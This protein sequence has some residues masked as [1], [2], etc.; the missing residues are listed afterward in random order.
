MIDVINHIGTKKKVIEM[1]TEWH[2]LTTDQYI[3]VCRILCMAITEEEARLRILKLL[4]GLSDYEFLRPSRRQRINQRLMLQYF[5]KLFPEIDFVFSEE[6]LFSKNFIPK[7]SHRGITYYGPSDKLANLTGDELEKT[8]FFYSAF[9]ATK[10]HELLIGIIATIYREEAPEKNARD[11]R[12][13]FDDADIEP[14]MA[15]LEGL[16][17]Y[18]VLGIRMFY[19]RSLMMWQKDYSKVFKEGKE[20]NKKPDLQ[21]WRKLNRAMAGPKR[22]TVNDV[23]KLT[24]GELMFELSELENEREAYDKVVESMKNK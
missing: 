4:M 5:E 20:K 21:A 8:D 9:N 16:P 7:F 6:K 18:I 19:E 14:R 24:I 3:G 23:K 13:D 11:N 10:K 12:K 15:A 17:E 2:E 1:P 22:G